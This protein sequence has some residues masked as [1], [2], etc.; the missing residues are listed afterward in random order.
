MS[1]KASDHKAQQLK[2]AGSQKSHIYVSKTKAG[3]HPVGPAAEWLTL[4]VL[5]VSS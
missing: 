2:N 5:L 3:T 4:H 1:A